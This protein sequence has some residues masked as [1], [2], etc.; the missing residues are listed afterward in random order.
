MTKKY[1]C[2]PSAILVSSAPFCSQWWGLYPAETAHPARDTIRRGHSDVSEPSAGSRASFI[3]I[4]TTWRCSE[5]LCQGGNSGK[6]KICSCSESHQATWSITDSQGNESCAEQNKHLCCTWYLLQH[7]SR[8]TCLKTTLYKVWNAGQK[9][10][11][12]CRF[13]RIRV[14][15]LLSDFIPSTKCFLQKEKKIVSSSLKAIVE[16]PVFDWN[17]GGF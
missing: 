6:M 5:M 13:H 14:S 3:S 1:F 4:Y 2:F 15:K 11:L 17:G 12:G 8:T 10:L 7:R 9:T 16:R